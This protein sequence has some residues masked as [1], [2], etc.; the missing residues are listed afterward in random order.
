MDFEHNRNFRRAK[1]EKAPHSEPA[2]SARTFRRDSRH[3]VSDAAATRHHPLITGEINEAISKRRWTDGDLFDKLYPRLCEISHRQLRK[4]W[5]REVLET[6]E[7]VSELYFKLCRENLPQMENRAHFFG[8]CARL[9]RQI[10]IAR[11]RRLNAVIHGG[12]IQ[13]T[14][15]DESMKVVETAFDDMLRLDRA[16]K[17][18]RRYDPWLHLV[19]SVHLYLEMTISETAEA[20]NV[21]ESKIKVD[22]RYAKAWLKVELS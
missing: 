2:D 14:T 4:G 17:K 13:F 9:V 7:L 16:M 11:V 3:S 22:Y 19:V 15:I 12:K 10:L 18:L 20:L 5:P 21:S 8:I 1:R 6:R